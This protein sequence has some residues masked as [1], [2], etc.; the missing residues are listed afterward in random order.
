M[1]RGLVR[2]VRYAMTD[3]P[4]CV[5][6]RVAEFPRG[7]SRFFAASFEPCLM[8]CFISPR[9]RCRGAEEGEHERGE[10]EVATVHGVCPPNKC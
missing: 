4:G 7:V 8:S 2:R 3:R 5:G 9:S 1:A 6:G 10:R